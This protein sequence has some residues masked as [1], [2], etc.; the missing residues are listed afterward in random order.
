MGA[1]L[2]TLEE[3]GYI[4]FASAKDSVKGFTV[5]QLKDLLAQTKGCSTTGKKADLVV[6]L[7]P[8][9]E[10]LATGIQPKYVLTEIGQQEL[11]ENA[12]VPYM[13]SVHNKTTEDDRFG[14]TFNVWSIK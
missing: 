5:Q 2:R 8:E 4:V 7:I 9:D 10:L 14:I 12:Y 13:H 6:Q 3:R 11:S 1:A